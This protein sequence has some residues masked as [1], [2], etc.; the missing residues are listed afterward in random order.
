MLAESAIVL[1]LLWLAHRKGKKPPEET[2]TPSDPLDEVLI[3]WNEADNFTYRDL[4]RS[5]MVMGATGSGKS[6]S[7]GRALAIA[8]AGCTN[9]GM[10]II[11]SK[12]EDE[13][14]WKNILRDREMII[15]S[16]QH[17]NRFNV[18]RHLVKS[19]ADA[20][21]I[22]EF[23]MT[24]AESMQRAEGTDSEPFWITQNQRGIHNAVEI[25]LLADGTLDATTLHAFINDAATDPLAV[26]SPEWQK[27]VHYQTVARAY[28]ATKTPAQQ[29]DFRQA[30]AYWME[31]VPKMGDKM[32]S[33]IYA[34][35][36]GILHPFCTGTVRELIGSDTNFELDN[37]KI[38]FVD[39]S[40][41]SYGASGACV[42]GAFK[43]VMQ[44]HVLKRKDWK[45]IIL[46]WIDEY[47]N[48]ITG[49]DAKYLA[50]CRSHGGA[51]IVLTQSMHSFYSS[52]GGKEA[53]SKAKML[54]TSFGHKC[55]MAL[56]DDESAQYACSLVG[57]DIR[58]LA[59]T[60]YHGGA[61]AKESP[62][63]AFNTSVTEHVEDVILPR[64]FMTGHLTGGAACG[65]VCTGWLIRSGQEFS[66]GMNA[67]KVSLSQR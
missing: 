62:Q 25:L 19:G 15:V 23:I 28:A 50:E 64:Y 40:V 47:Q 44:R 30:E 7:I 22:T 41:S 39:M 45:H 54:M 43:F 42:G 2:P 18:I 36:F 63:G 8:I 24:V 10:L 21:E 32:R 3:W 67:I 57:K 34:G 38:I 61:K 48:H 29:Q 1:V 9:I 20:R 16:P 14:F 26:Q 52:I 12:P 13:D 66:N 46:I 31:E 53:Q 33:S 35:I 51:M 4:L 59:S 37:G 11:G 65:Y 49:Y 56:G 5:F 17:N 6:S 27:G 55:F 58:R 60:S